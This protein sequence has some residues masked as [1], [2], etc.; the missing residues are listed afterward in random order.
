MNDNKRTGEEFRLKRMIL[1]YQISEDEKKNYEDVCSWTGVDI[2]WIREEE[3]DVPIGYLVM[4]A[5]ETY[6]NMLRTEQGPVFEEPMMIMAGF[7]GDEISTFLRTLRESGIK[8]VDRK[9]MI[10]EYNAVWTS[11]ML[12][13]ELGK[14]HEAMKQ[15]RKQQ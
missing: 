13:E 9:A 12:H 4:G 7:M 10:T 2:R 6:R 11:L 1:L 8:P 3:Y 15:Y 14:E 5:E